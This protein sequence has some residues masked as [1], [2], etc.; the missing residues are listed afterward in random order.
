MDQ[1]I[2]AP[3]SSTN[4]LKNW[5]CSTQFFLYVSQEESESMLPY[6]K[7]GTKDFDIGGKIEMQLER[8]HFRPSLEREIS[9][10]DEEFT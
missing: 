2:P 7:W 10:G 9:F 4:L 1:V 3:K 5:I 8:L 6:L